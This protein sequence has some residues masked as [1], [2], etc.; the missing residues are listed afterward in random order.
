MTIYGD[1]LT[2]P[3]PI[4]CINSEKKPLTL[5]DFKIEKPGFEKREEEVENIPM[6]FDPYS[7]NNVVAMM[8]KMSYFPGINLGKTMK[9]AAIRVLTMSTTTPPFGL[10]YK[11]MNDDLL[12]MEVRRMARAKAKAKG[13]PNPLEP[14]KPYTPTLNKKF[15]KARDTQHYWGFPE[16]RYYPE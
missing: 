6:D 5:D 14:L 13:L 9:G 3:K 11:P 15:V 16:P 8:R 10:G 12:E 7:N 2:V 1:T 4:F